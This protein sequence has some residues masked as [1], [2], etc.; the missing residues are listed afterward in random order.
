MMPAQYECSLLALR[1]YQAAKSDSVDELLAVACTFRNRVHRYG[2]TYS[3]ILEAAEL[4]RG[5]PD[6]RHP[7]MIDPQN[8]LLAAVEAIYR[9]EMP[10]MT[11]NHLFREGAT[12]F[13]RVVEHQGTGDWFETTILQNPTEHGLIGTFGVQQFFE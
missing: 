13:G 3:Q 4:N 8:G 2:K 9:N 12:F 11:S 1:S 5:W 10:D 6:V 7:A